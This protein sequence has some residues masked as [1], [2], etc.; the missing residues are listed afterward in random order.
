MKQQ[1][2]LGARLRLSEKKIAVRT[3]KTK[4]LQKNLKENLGWRAF[5][6]LNRH[7]AKP[8]KYGGQI[9]R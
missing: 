3:F 2:G 4:P 5:I 1:G 7:V 9:R 8:V 6:I